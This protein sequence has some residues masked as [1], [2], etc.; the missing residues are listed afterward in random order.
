MLSF[1]FYLLSTMGVSPRLTTPR[2]KPCLWLFPLIGSGQGIAHHRSSLGDLALEGQPSLICPWR[3]AAL[4][5][6]LFML[7]SVCPPAP[8][9]AAL[10]QDPDAA[11]LPH[12]HLHNN[13]I[14][15]L[16]A[17]S[18]EGLQNLETL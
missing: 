1:A 9:H 11:L 6:W 8:R 12:R 5:G 15:H 14:Q 2:P 4:L 18:F 10:G 13:R 17:H 16:G 7:E 3:Q